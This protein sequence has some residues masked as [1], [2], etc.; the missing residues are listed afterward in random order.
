MVFV[1][2]IYHWG[3]K[4]YIF[5]RAYCSFCGRTNRPIRS[6]TTWEVAHV[7]FVPLM[8]WG[9]IRVVCQC[10]TCKSFFRLYFKGRK[11]KSAV[12]KQRDDALKHVGQNIDQTLEDIAFLAH[13]GDFEGAQSILD[14][15][16]ARD[17]SGY[18]LAEARLL[19]LRGEVEK[20][21]CSFHRAVKLDSESGMP[22]YWFG[23]FLLIQERDEDAV[24][25]LRRA[26]E[27]S[28]SEDC[29]VLL[30]D[31]I[32]VR[33]QQKNWHGLA[34]IM[35]EIKYLAPDAISDKRSAK[36]YSKACRKS[37]RNLDIANPY[38][39]V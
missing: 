17:E 2:G 32:H 26:Y 20:A 25:H 35:T 33:K 12:E 6:Y 23:H 19:A 30:K 9:K 29:I 27:L 36:L 10:L 22:N 37:G 5:D 24:V 7:M 8:P 14:E 34:T 3:K 39:Q 28:A 31:F 4:D 18:A 16:T 1:S 38:A 21:E 11:L 15:L 13:L